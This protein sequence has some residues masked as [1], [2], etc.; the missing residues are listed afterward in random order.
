MTLLLVSLLIFS[1]LEVLPGD[2]AT[3]MLGRD[4]TPESL[5]HTA[6]ATPPR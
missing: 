6:G 4:A 2:V 1:M 5:A 3:R